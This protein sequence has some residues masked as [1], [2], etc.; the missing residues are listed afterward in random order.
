LLRSHRKI[1]KTALRQVIKTSWKIPTSQSWQYTGL[2]T[3]KGLYGDK[4]QGACITHTASE[5]PHSSSLLPLTGA[6]G[7]TPYAV[8]MSILLP[9]RARTLPTIHPQ[10]VIK[11]GSLQR[12]SCGALPITQTPMQGRVKGGNCIGALS[13]AVR[14]PDD[15]RA[16]PRSAQPLLTDA[17]RGES[18]GEA[19]AESLKRR[20]T[21]PD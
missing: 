14:P 2:E 1:Y 15:L 16:Q 13:A 4:R 9:L 12:I 6:T 20:L 11:R 10:A 18:G 7:F 17:G 5:G 8:S 3:A 19:P 21:P